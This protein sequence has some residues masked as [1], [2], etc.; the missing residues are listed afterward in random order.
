MSEIQSKTPEELIVGF[1]NN[2]SRELRKTKESIMDLNR[3]HTEKLTRE[4]NLDILKDKCSELKNNPNLEIFWEV[5]EESPPIAGK[6]KVNI[7]EE[8]G[9]RNDIEN[10]LIIHKNFFYSSCKCYT[11]HSW[12]FKLLNQ[13]FD[14]KQFDK[15]TNKKNTLDLNIF[16][17]YLKKNTNKLYE[18]SESRHAASKPGSEESHEK[19]TLI[20]DLFPERHGKTVKNRKDEDQKNYINA[21]KALLSTIENTIKE[22]EIENK[23]INF[24]HSFIWHGH[25]DN[26]QQFPIQF[27][28]AIVEN[29]KCNLGKCGIL[30]YRTKGWFNKKEDCSDESYY[31]IC[32][33]ENNQ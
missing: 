10:N 29:W 30:I 13:Q 24:T 16:K 23:K 7:C 2:N 9:C 26:S 25:V 12:K 20:I 14:F 28:D 22:I 17:S 5:F 15:E 31:S 33:M 6:D 3:K 27:F 8:E 11:G 21:T 19:V 4:V 32:Q 18:L 1:F